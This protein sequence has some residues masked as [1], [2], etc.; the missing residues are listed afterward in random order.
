MVSPNRKPRHRRRPTPMKKGHVP[1]NQP[2]MELVIEHV[3]ARGDGVTE[4]EIKIGWDVRTRPFFVPYSLPGERLLVQPELDRGEGIVAR[5]VELLEASPDRVEPPCPHFMACGGCLLQ[6]WEDSA[7]A[8]WKLAQVKLQLGRVG[9]GD[10]PIE[11]LHRSPSASRRRADLAA[12]HLKG[13]VVLGFHERLGKRIEPIVHCLVIRPELDAMLAPIKALLETLLA[14]GEDAS[15]HLTLTE[16]GIDL[17]LTL[18][19]RPDLTARETLAAFAESHDLARLSLK[20]MDDAGEFLDPVSARRDPVLRFGGVPVIPSPGGFLQATAEGEAEM[21]SRV[22]AAAEGAGKR[23]D[24]F[25]GIGTLSLPL[26]VGGLVRGVDGDPAAIGALRRSVD[27]AGLGP[28]LTTEVRDLFR[29]PVT[30]EELSAFDIVIFDPPR[31]GAKAQ[32]AEL[33]ASK[34]PTVVAVSCNPATLAR[35]LRVLVD[36]GYEIETIRPIDQF[37]W[38]PHIEVVAL[39]KRT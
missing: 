19:S 5:P 22:L 25:C 11:D 16:A 14:V 23:L 39:L 37:P 27:A 35:D 30:V 34:V 26:V 28:R 9:L 6:H 12:R 10:V 4:A 33:A 18:P 20:A 32:A 38:T 1:A 3:G 31:A 13:G 7:Y 29:D 17:L 36:G 15:V 24:L 21:T 8:A 2:P